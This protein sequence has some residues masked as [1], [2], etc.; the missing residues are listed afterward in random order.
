MTGGSLAEP[1]HR[2]KGR[3]LLSS[4]L[5][6]GVAMSLLVS[7]LSLSSNCPLKRSLSPSANTGLLSDAVNSN[8]K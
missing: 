4:V 7:P 1:R 3:S 6:A 2:A 8:R 5:Q